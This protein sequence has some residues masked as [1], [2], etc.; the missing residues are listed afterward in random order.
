MANKNQPN[1]LAKPKPGPPTQRYLDIAEIKEDVVILKDGT[2]RAVLMTSS[3]NFALKSVDEQQATIQAYMQFLNGLEHPIQI[4]V[5]SRKMNVEKYMQYLETQERDM[6]NQLLKAQIRDYRSFVGDLIELGEIMQK[7]FY[8]VVPYDPVAD[9]KKGS[10]MSRV[11]AAI[12]PSGII[13]LTK[14]QFKERKLAL[15]QRVNIVQSGLTGIGL[16]STALDTQGLIELYYTVYNPESY[17]NQKLTDVS[18]LRLE[19]QV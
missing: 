4:V 16:Q 18:N 5:Q 7:R 15:T 19:D 3:I 17:D 8:V 10:F 12:T 6:K 9:N 11:Q 13:K 2:L 14:K 1:K